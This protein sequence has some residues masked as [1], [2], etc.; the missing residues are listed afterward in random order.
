MNDQQVR[1]DALDPTQSFIVQAPA[2]SGKTTLLTSRYVSLLETVEQPEE[3]LAMTFTR[4][5][6]AE[7][8][9]RILE[10]LHPDSGA[11]LPQHSA[12]LAVERVRKR[13]REFGWNLHQQPARLQI[14][15]F[16]ALATALIRC[17]P[18][19]SRFGSVPGV[20]Q[21]PE[22]VYSAAAVNTIES[23]SSASDELRRSMRLL[24]EQLDNNSRRLQEL[25]V[26]MLSSRDQWLRILIN[27]SFS[28]DDKLHMEDVWRGLNETHFD[29]LIRMI[30]SNSRDAL[31]LDSIYHSIPD[32]LEYWQQVAEALLTKAGDWRKRLTSAQS[33]GDLSKETLQ[34][35]ID[36][37]SE[38]PMLNE[39][40]AR[41]G[42]SL[43][44]PRY[45]D[46]QWAVLQAASIVLQNAVAELK[47]EFRKRGAVD[48]IEIAQRA[49]EALGKPESPTDLSL[50]LD[51]RF[52]HILVDEFQDSSTNQ[53]QL[54]KSLTGGWENGDGRTIFLVGDPMQS[55]YRFREA[56]VGIYLSVVDRGLGHIDPKPLR[57]NQNFRSSAG[58][59]NWFN[60]VFESAFPSESDVVTSRVAYSPCISDIDGGTDSPIRIWLQ[61]PK[62]AEGIRLS[63]QQLSQVEAKKVAGDIREYLNRSEGLDVK[64][65]VLVRNRSHV[66]HLIPLLDGDN[67]RY[68]AA[69]IFPLAERPVVQ[70]ILSLTR[71]MLN[72]ANRSS[73]LAILRAPWCGL[74]L[75]DLLVISEDRDATIWKQLN[76]TMVIDKLSDDGRHRVHRVRRILNDALSVRGRLGLRQWIEDTWVLL[77][78]PACVSHS[79]DQNA[80][81]FLDFMEN[82]AKGA[83]VENL[84]RFEE[85][86]GSLFA[87][88]ECAPD[89]ADVHIMT[90]H[91]AKGLEYDAVFIPSFSRTS[92]RSSSPL[93]VWSE[94]LLDYSGNEL[95]ISPIHDIGS[96]ASDPMY[97]F[98][99]EWNKEKDLMELTR[100]VYV[101]CTRAKAELHLYGSHEYDADIPD[102]VKQPATGTLLGSLWSG[103]VGS[104][105]KSVN[106][107]EVGFGLEDA[108]P[109]EID[110]PTVPV[111]SRLP[112]NWN[113]PEPPPSLVLPDRELETPGN[114]DTIDFDWAGSVA[115]W[116]GK[117]VHRWLNR[118]VQSGSDNWGP[119][120]LRME[121]PKWRI[122]LLSMGM[123]A[124]EEGFDQAIH[125]IET[126]LT[127][128]FADPTGRWLL[129]SRHR[130]GQAEYRMTGYI[131]GMFK[132][133]ILDRTFVDD[134]GVRWIVDYKTGTTTGNVDDFLDNEVKRYREQLE[135]YRKIISG[136]ES[137]P[138]K[139]GLYFPIFP[140]WREVE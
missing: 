43:P 109:E 8:R 82:Y 30:P 133:V 122:A 118:I 39:K 119:E 127:N 107:T 42:R 139:L 28:A 6:T 105:F 126:A 63:A 104:D 67:I 47:L 113:L 129:D 68:Y 23:V 84:E 96:T 74:T 136:I 77:G 76:Q 75:D 91:G 12:N 13:S 60:E 101:G 95:L 59:V 17:M 4:K 33:F 58:L 31:G 55:I 66:K 93:L 98:L 35:V 18:W 140:D 36:E 110:A 87:V 3:I 86:M 114:Q 14:M 137:R 78:G 103:L 56:E 21:D 32:S 81:L 125:N 124:E 121:R 48:F 108:L 41:V 132:N 10:V 27:K 134:D 7:M 72:L 25:I 117:I 73:W 80:R 26:S 70:D 44:N 51:Y 100:L 61:N 112:A 123:S 57:L 52:R 62:T 54:L 111:L 120:R 34:Q 16:D 92:A 128:V 45:G 1:E 89:E 37:C 130:D 90:I 135:Q 19:S 116:V 79:D 83:E 131:N 97:D 65:A 11:E 5:A 2:G 9:E 46:R 106:W 15:T 22:D 50:V 138:I 71:A 38:V 20:L 85:Q 99:K 40:L 69:E 49:V 88:P 64:A 53:H 94:I 102:E 115:V 24:H 29:A